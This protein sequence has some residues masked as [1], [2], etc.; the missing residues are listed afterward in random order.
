MITYFLEGGG[1][2]ICSKV[3]TLGKVVNLNVDSYYLVSGENTG[4]KNCGKL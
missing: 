1:E 4:T 2:G 3:V